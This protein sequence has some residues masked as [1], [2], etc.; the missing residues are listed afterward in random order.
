[1]SSDGEQVSGIF[2]DTYS[3]APGRNLVINTDFLRVRDNGHIAV[4]TLGDGDGGNFFL[5]AKTIELSGVSA[6]FPNI[7]TGLFVDT[8]SAG[9]GGNLI[10]ET[11]QLSITDGASIIAGTQ[12]DSTGQGGNVN[13]R[14][15]ESIEVAGEAFEISSNLTADTFSSGDGGDVVLETAQL[16]VKAGGQISVTT[17][18]SGDAGNLT[19]QAD[20]IDITGLSPSSAFSGL[21]ASTESSGRGGDLIIDAN[22]IRVTDGGI[23]SVATFGSGHG[24]NIEIQANMMEISGAAI[25][26]SGTLNGVTSFVAPAFLNFNEAEVPPATGNGGDIAI[27]ANQ[28]LLSDG[29]QIDAST[30][31][32]GSAG[33]ITLNINELTLTGISEVLDGGTQ[34]PSRILSSSETGSAAGSIGITS[35][36]LTLQNGAE[37]NVSS[38]SSGDAGNLT[39]NTGTLQLDNGGRLLAEVNGGEQGN[40]RLFPNDLLVLRRNSSITTTA[41]GRSTGGNIEIQSPFIVGIAGENSDIVANAVQ[42]N[43]GNISIATQGVFGLA[44][45]DRLTPDNDITASS[46]FGLDGTVEINSPEADP[47]SQVLELPDTLVD[48]S[49]LVRPGCS[50]D[51][52]Q[53][54][55]AG[56]G[57]LPSSPMESM[58]GDRPWF[59]LRNPSVV[60]NNASDH[61]VSNPVERPLVVEP[62]QEAVGMAIAPNGT[63]HLIASDAQNTNIPHASCTS[64]P[65]IL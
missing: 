52:D 34:I 23:I 7:A 12:E 27:T 9:T 49:Q 25:D 5:T 55:L 58:G 18:G 4:G 47:S 41:S 22:D 36:R 62:I 26:F 60:V 44:F 50:L 54:V 8:L 64:Q 56:R 35:D 61:F 17:F 1:M 42:G 14:A 38:L 2:A 13:I 46:E 16:T 6:D 24:G 48:I 10:I 33:N 59:D 65:N 40:I 15:T 63:L 39:L 45:R 51:E 57:G 30:F 20:A 31:G 21:F 29:G 32:R 53:F 37:I 3:S 43:G 11:R 28:L 19:V